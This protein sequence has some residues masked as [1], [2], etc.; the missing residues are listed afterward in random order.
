M[1]SC[2]A[3]VVRFRAVLAG[4]MVEAEMVEWAIEGVDD[5]FGRR[6]G[7]PVGEDR[8]DDRGFTVIEGCFLEME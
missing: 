8:L 4:V 6:V 3:V 7:S 2:L 1:R 5:E